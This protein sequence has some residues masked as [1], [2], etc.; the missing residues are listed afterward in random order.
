MNDKNNEPVLPENSQE[1]NMENIEKMPKLL[2]VSI[3]MTSYNRLNLLKKSIESIN[4]R[5][6]YPF[7]II[8]VDNNSTDGSRE[9]LKE[10]KVLGKIFDHL[11]LPE[12]VGQSMA[13][14]KGLDLIN[15]WEA[16]RPSNDLFVGTN[17]DLLAPKLSPCWL[18]RLLHLFEKS[19]ADGIGGIALRIERSSRMDIDEEKD[20][21]ILQKSFPNVFRMI[22]RSDLKK[23]GDE[24]F[25]NLRHWDSHPLATKFQEVLKKKYALA[26]NLYAS[27][28][29]FELENKGYDPSD[30]SYFTYPGEEKLTVPKE[31]PYPEI[32]DKTLIPINIKSNAD[33]AEHQKRLKY[34]GQYVDYDISNIKKEDI[35]RSSKV[36]GPVRTIEH[37]E[38]K[39]HIKGERVI[40]LGCANKK[41][42]DDATGVDIL[43]FDCVDVV[44]KA[45]DLW[46]LKDG[47]A[48]TVVASHLLEHFN[49]TKKVIAEWLRVLRV[50]GVLGF[51]IPD[52]DRADTISDPAHKV[53][54]TIPVLKVIMTKVFNVNLV[55]L[56]K[57]ETN[58][59]SIICVVEKK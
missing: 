40:D 37:N 46:W 34:W 28:I 12:N 3:L 38:L 53:A 8:V 57:I 21:I 42:I 7:R 24:P 58:K 59:P 27:H 41:I 15:E 6:F 5:T 54:L 48:D 23:L 44:A 31:K 45:D 32:D 18:E 39:K 30:K 43:P 10:C 50:G 1:N 25:G 16:R 9:Y 56:E 17:E 36:F 52:G 19:E 13:L 26:T 14:N 33:F 22:R 51:V 29:G 47:E 11:F 2:P 55:R 35:Q 4:E 49:D 20:L